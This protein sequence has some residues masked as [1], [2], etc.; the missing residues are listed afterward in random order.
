MMSVENAARRVSRGGGLVVRP[1]PIRFLAIQQTIF[2]SFL[3]VSML[4]WLTILIWSFY[5]DKSYVES[6]VSFLHEVVPQA[7]KK[8]CYCLNKIYLYNVI[9]Y[10]SAIFALPVVGFFIGVVFQVI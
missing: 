2:A 3:D 9:L 7:S 1:Q 4:R 8:L 6:V 5:S 10:L